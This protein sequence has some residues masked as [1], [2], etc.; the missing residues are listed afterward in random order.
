MAGWP[1]STQRWKRLRLSKLTEQPLC[2]HC[3]AGGLLVFA[4]V[5]DHIRP[6]KHGGDPFPALDGLTSLCPSCHSAKTARGIEAGAVRTDREAKRK[7]VAADGSPLDAAH[8]WNGGNGFL[9]AATLQRRMPPD[10]LPSRIPLTIVCGPPGSGKSSYVRQSAGP[11]DT[12]ICLDTIIMKLTGL[13]EHHSLPWALSKA[14]EIRNQKLHCLATTS[15][16]ERAWF[17]V[18]APNPRDRAAWKARLGGEVVVLTTPLI[19]C[20]RRIK[21]DAARAGLASGMIEVATKW[22]ER[23]PHLR[24]IGS[25][26]IQM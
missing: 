14:L 3:N 17:I 13:P 16:Y 9:S 18:S 1:Y 7:G 21:A 5:V 11:N 25:P 2:E 23:N 26:H 6:V 12:V 22:W 19:E 15:K 8:P 4:S 24:G 10:L 20:V